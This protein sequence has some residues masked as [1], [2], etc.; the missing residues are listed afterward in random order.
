MGLALLPEGAILP[1]LSNHPHTCTPPCSLCTSVMHMVE[2]DPL[3]DSMVGQ[4]GLT[5]LALEA[6]KVSL[7]LPLP[8]AEQLWLSPTA[9]GGCM[10][11]G[12]QAVRLC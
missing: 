2:L 6:R 12:C 1:S 7:P 3:K 5:G 10:P 11:S 8:G 9:V 4:A